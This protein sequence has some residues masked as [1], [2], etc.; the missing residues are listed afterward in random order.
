MERLLGISQAEIND[1][2]VGNWLFVLVA[3]DGTEYY[4]AFYADAR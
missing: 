4:P 1:A 2:V 3:T